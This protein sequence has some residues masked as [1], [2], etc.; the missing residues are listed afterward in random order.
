VFSR[1]PENRARFVQQMQNLYDSSNP[2]KP[3]IVA[4]DSIQTAL[5]DTDI[6]CVT[7][8]GREPV[9]DLAH[10]RPGALITSINPTAVPQRPG[11]RVIVSTLEGPEIHPSGWEPHTGFSMP[12]PTTTLVDIITG[13]TTARSHENEQVLYM[14]LGAGVWDGALLHFISSWAREHGAGTEFFLTAKKTQRE[15]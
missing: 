8:D 15:S 5:A 11:T 13:Q 6:V 4:V 14:Q 1:Q 9:L 2:G 10:V 12:T 3:Q 7:V